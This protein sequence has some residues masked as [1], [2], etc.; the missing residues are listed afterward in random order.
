MTISILCVSSPAGRL[1]VGYVADIGSRIVVGI[2]GTN[3]DSIRSMSINIDFLL[4]TLES[5]YFP[6]MG[7]AKVHRGFYKAF[8][9]ISAPILTALQAATASGK[10]VVVTGH[11]Q[12][13]AVGMILAL[14]LQTKLQV[15]V[16][17]KLFAAPRVGNP[18]WAD[19]VD[20]V[21]G[22]R[23][24]HI[25]NFNDVVPH[26]PFMHWGYRHPSGE[27]YITEVGGQEYRLCEGQENERCAGQWNDLRGEMGSFFDYITTST[28]SGP[29]AGVRV[30]DDKCPS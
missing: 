3:T 30:T 15:S 20:R 26:L 14:Y 4:T 27:V 7:G 12:G 24:Q 29:F 6:N 8:K 18:D 25:V 19:A 21:L 11:S 5:S 1:T 23:Q 10:D 22:P 13:A 16:H 2:A 17:A 9:R 28:H